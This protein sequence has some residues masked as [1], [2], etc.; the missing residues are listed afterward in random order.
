MTWQGARSS[1]SEHKIRY[2]PPMLC[3]KMKLSLN[4]EK[5][6]AAQRI[7]RNMLLCTYN[8]G[9]ESL[10]ILSTLWFKSVEEERIKCATNSICHPRQNSWWMRH[11]ENR[12]VDNKS[13]PQI[14][15]KIH[16]TRIIDMAWNTISDQLLVI[17]LMEKR[18]KK[19]KQD[20]GRNERNV[21]K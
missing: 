15:R 16:W 8:R 20:R 11:F 2:G 17:L 18:Q 1:F 7:C 21:H 5:T 3:N 19:K 6:T 14:T 10:P 12:W 4:R 9:V 13:S